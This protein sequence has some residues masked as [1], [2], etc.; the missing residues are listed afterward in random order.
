MDYRA[1]FAGWAAVTGDS[2]A[3]VIVRLFHGDRRTLA[4]VV[5]V[6]RSILTT[7][8]VTD[9]RLQQML[10]DLAVRLVLEKAQTEP[11]WVHEH[12]GEDDALV[13]VTDPSL[14]SPT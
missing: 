6:P 11:A 12:A 14:L 5:R 10:P 13:R 8:G 2:S 4:A 9:E 3:G 1:E 7:W